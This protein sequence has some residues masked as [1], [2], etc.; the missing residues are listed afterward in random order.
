M[1][2]LQWTL[3][4]TIRNL[5]FNLLTLRSNGGLGCLGGSVGRVSNFD[6]GHDLTV[7][8]FKPCIQLSTD[9]TEPAVDSLSPSLSAPPLV[10]LSLSK[11]NKH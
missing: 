11:I 5:G 7:H 1:D 6:S 4:V 9:S 10:M 2:G 8:E 3:N